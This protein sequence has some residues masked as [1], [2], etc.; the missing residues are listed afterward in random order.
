MRL[1]LATALL[2]VAGF[3]SADD[4]KP[5]PKVTVTGT[6][7]LDGKPLG[8]CGVTFHTVEAGK[9]LLPFRTATDKD[10]KFTIEV[11]ADEYNVTCLKIVADEATKKVITVTPSKY[12]S[13]KTSG[14]KAVV[15][16]EKATFDIA[17]ASK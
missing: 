16:G 6:L 17:L 3:V 5:A 14:I 4:K 2:L 10:G 15:K 7:T 12:A 9:T 8:E 13:P 11:P 1:L